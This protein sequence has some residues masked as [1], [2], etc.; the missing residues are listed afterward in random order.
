MSNAPNAD[1]GRV[2]C[3]CC[4]ED[5]AAAGRTICLRCI[6]C[7]CRLSV[8]CDRPMADFDLASNDSLGAA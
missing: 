4:G 5:V 2:V 3:R 7:D 1:F 6:E 8:G